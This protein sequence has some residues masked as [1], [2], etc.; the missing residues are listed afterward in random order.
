LPSSDYI[1][2]AF[3]RIRSFGLIAVLPEDQGERVG[4]GL[5]VIDDED[6]AVL[7]HHILSCLHLILGIDIH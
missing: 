3:S 2:R 6:F 5:F 4:C 1:N 7:A